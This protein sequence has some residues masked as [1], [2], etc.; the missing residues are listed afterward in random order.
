MDNKLSKIYA[1]AHVVPIT[2]ASKIVLM[3]DCHRG[4]GGWNDNLSKN[5]SV[6]CGALEYYFD[7]GYTYIEI[8]DGDELWENYD[9]KVIADTHRD[10]FRLLSK[11]HQYGRLYMIY[12][13]HDMVKRYE[14]FIAGSLYRYY[15]AGLKKELPLF[16][17]I[18]LHEALLLRHAETGGDIL[19]VHGHQVDFFN[20][21]LWKLAR[22]LVRHLWRPLEAFGINNP[23]SAARNNKRSSKVETRLAL[24]AQSENKMLIAGHTHK[25]VFPEAGT[26][27]YFNDG[28]CV[29]PRCVTAMEISEGSVILVKWCVSA[30]QGGILYVKREVIAGPEKLSAYLT[31]GKNKQ[32]EKLSSG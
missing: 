16:E 30:M 22:F 23:T 27:L 8:G 6:Y 26:S 25:P 5:E 29:H 4:D 15:D 31:P 10:A 7:R 14:K 21:G 2:D 1:S 28:S 12:G 13:N 11:F 20:N 3:S 24:W 19:L 32:A 17:N 18:K 9:F